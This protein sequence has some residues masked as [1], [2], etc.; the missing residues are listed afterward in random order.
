LQ[1]KGL[2]ELLT[3]EKG[4]GAAVKAQETKD[5]GP[6]DKQTNKDTEKQNKE[7]QPQREEEGGAE[8]GGAPVSPKKK[9]GTPKKRA[10]KVTEKAAEVGLE[11]YEDEEDEVKKPKKQTNG[12]KNSDKKKE[13]VKRSHVPWNGEEYPR[14]TA[15]L[16]CDDDG[17][18]GGGLRVEV[19]AKKPGRGQWQKVLFSLD[20]T[21]LDG[22]DNLPEKTKHLVKGSFHKALTGC[23][24]QK[25]PNALRLALAGTT[26]AKDI[27]PVVAAG[28]E[29]DGRREMDGDSVG[30]GNPIANASLF[31]IE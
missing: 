5:K 21:Q 18:D 28:G 24:G 25:W 7:K 31:D 30:L 23:Y 6:K 26:W 19:H 22:I 10:R 17:A 12:I 27:L 3:P 4:N 9:A 13:S 8:A 16:K 2:M 29:M 11:D 14:I 1:P 15:V 20:S